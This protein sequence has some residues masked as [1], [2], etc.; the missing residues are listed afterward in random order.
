MSFESSPQNVEE[1]E[2]KAF[3]IAGKLD[4]IFL[5]TKFSVLEHAIR[6]MGANTRETLKLALLK[7]E[8]VA[9]EAEK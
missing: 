1:A 3:E 2:R 4:E 6:M 5:D 9:I 8:R 7:A